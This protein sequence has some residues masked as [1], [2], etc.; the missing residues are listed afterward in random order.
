[1]IRVGIGQLVAA[2]LFVLNA[3]V[4]LNHPVLRVLDVAFAAFLIWTAFDKI[5]PPGTPL[6]LEPEKRFV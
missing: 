4:L 3:C 6:D 5:D 1:M 2:I